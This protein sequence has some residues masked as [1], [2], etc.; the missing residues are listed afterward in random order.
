MT[1]PELLWSVSPF[2]PSNCTRCQNVH[3]SHQSIIHLQYFLLSFAVPVAKLPGQ[4][5]RVD[6]RE[7]FDMAD[8]DRNYGLTCSPP[9]ERQIQLRD[10]D[11]PKP[12][13]LCNIHQRIL[14]NILSSAPNVQKYLHRKLHIRL[15]KLV[16]H[17]CCSSLSEKRAI[18]S[19]KWI[20]KMILETVFASCA[21][22][23][24]SKRKLLR[25]YC[26][27]LPLAVSGRTNRALGFFL[28][29]N[30]TLAANIA[31]L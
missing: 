8:L 6:K 2:Q 24:Y 15:M 27:P 12:Q 31:C 21:Y 3:P 7:R 4:L 28:A 30:R 26:A 1:I 22:S 13:V 9:S 20:I 11:F 25:V 19:L 16:C 14:C 10:L 18:S 5:P 29:N 23:N 17:K